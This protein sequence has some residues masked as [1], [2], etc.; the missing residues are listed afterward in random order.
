[1]VQVECRKE[2]GYDSTVQFYRNELDVL[3]LDHFG[4]I[5]EPYTNEILKSLPLVCREISD[6]MV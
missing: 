6:M 2:F 5:R 1:M 4:V 3:V